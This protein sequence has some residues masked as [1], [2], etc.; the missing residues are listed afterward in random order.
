MSDAEQDIKLFSQKLN[1]LSKK[2]ASLEGELK[3]INSNLLSHGLNEGANIE[4]FLKEE[5]EE[6]DKMKYILN[7]LLDEIEDGLNQI[8][9]IP[10]AEE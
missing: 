3:Q 5:K 8:E 2:K 1:T 7:D 9:G 4:L 10:S 6:L